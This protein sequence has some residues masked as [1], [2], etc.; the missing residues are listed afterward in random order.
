MPIDETA[1]YQSIHYTGM[2]SA[3]FALSR[4][5]IPQLTLATVLPR[6]G[7]VFLPTPKG[8][9]ETTYG[10][11]SEIRLTN[12]NR[13]IPRLP[14]VPDCWA[15]SAW[16][17]IRSTWLNSWRTLFFLLGLFSQSYSQMSV[18]RASTAHVITAYL[19]E[20][21]WGNQS[22]QEKVQPS[23]PPAQR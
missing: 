19:A 14:L 22:R 11:T 3:A 20:T 1:P 21:A 23:H 15:V 6:R 17:D 5:N 10:L 2:N 4:F 7:L 12:L 8:N 9:S 16:D 18:P 13:P